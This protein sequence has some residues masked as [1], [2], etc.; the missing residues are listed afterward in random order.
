[1]YVHVQVAIT[2]ALEHVRPARLCRAAC[3]VLQGPS[4]PAATVRLSYQVVLVSAIPA[5]MPRLLQR[6]L[7]VPPVW[8]AAR[9]AVLPA[10]VWSATPRPTSFYR[11]QSAPASRATTCKEL[12]ALPAWPDALSVQLQR[13]AQPAM[14]LLTTLVAVVFACAI[15]HPAIS[16]AEGPAKRAP[17]SLLDA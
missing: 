6:A 7:L 4:A 3:S 13:H 16:Q 1:M 11:E 5:T 8:L 14:P 12:L 9:R 2:I 15:L 10:T 17:V